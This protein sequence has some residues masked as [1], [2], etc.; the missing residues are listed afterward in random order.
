MN[1]I[2]MKTQPSTAEN[3]ASSSGVKPVTLQNAA[4]IRIGYI[5]AC[6]HHEIVE[7]ARHSFSETVAQN[8]IAATQIEV[9]QVPGSLEI[10]LQA[11]ML[12]KSGRF[13]LIMQALSAAEMNA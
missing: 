10:P 2:Q 4:N 12:A 7:R 1:Q 13:D 8:G 9:F 5:E 3:T 6:W 11:K